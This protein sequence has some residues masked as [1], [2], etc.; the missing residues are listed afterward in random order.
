MFDGVIGQDQTRALDYLINQY[1]VKK[2]CLVYVL[3]FH[4]NELLNEFF[5]RDFG[6]CVLPLRDVP[7]LLWLTTVMKCVVSQ[8]NAHPE[9]TDDVKAMR[10]KLSYK[11]P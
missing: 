8:K 10:H 3:D 6:V 11:I 1:D 4:Q 5:V 9:I 2:T 7:D